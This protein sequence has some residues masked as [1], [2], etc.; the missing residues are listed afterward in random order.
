MKTIQHL[1]GACGERHLNLI[2]ILILF[3]ICFAL[4]K[5]LELWQMKKI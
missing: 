3:A 2:D 1:I 4:L 5:I